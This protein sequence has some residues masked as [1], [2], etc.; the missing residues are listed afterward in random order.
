MFIDASD[1]VRAAAL[2]IV[3]GAL[4]YTYREFRNRAVPYVKVI[5]VDGA[6]RKS[7]DIVPVPESIR[8]KTKG[9]FYIPKL[10]DK[11]TLA[12]IHQ[13]W[14]S[15]DDLERFAPAVLEYVDQALV[16]TDEDQ[17]VGV[18]SRLTNLTYFDRWMM[19]LLLTDSIKFRVQDPDVPEKIPVFY[20]S[21]PE[22]GGH[23]WL[24]FPGRTVRFGTRLNHP[25]IAAKSKPFIYEI[26]RLDRERVLDVL[27]QF[28][29]FVENEHHIAATVMTELQA[30]LN[31]NSRWAFSVYIA[32]LSAHPLIVQTAATLEI[33]DS[34]KASY[35]QQCYLAVLADSQD[36]SK[37]I[38]DTKK[39]VVIRPLSDTEV[40]LITSLTQGDMRMGSAIREAFDRKE[41][42]FRLAFTFEK[43]GLIKRQ[44]YRAQSTAFVQTNAL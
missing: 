15:A 5:D 9:A 8:T 35:E 20:E 28:K 2:T 34:N 10:A 24:S 36:G 12:D 3:A 33:M 21:D 29:E 44:R 32:N 31:A 22:S 43:V 17:L 37:S 18:M 19:V 4:G 23:A 41:A 42:E 14:D 26:S 38:R 1:E 7:T 13:A 27:R 6:I 39:P 16:S 11:S 30:V 40:V 25:A